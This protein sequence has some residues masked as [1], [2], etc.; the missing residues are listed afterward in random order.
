MKNSFSQKHPYISIILVGLICTFMTASGTAV[1]QIIGL[2]ENAQLEVTTVFLIISVAIGILIMSKSRFTLSDYG[3]CKSKKHVNKKVWW[4][5]PLFVVEIIPIAVAG[6]STEVTL[7]QYAI[8]LFFTTAVGFNE[9]IYFRGLAF[10]FL[11]EKGR[12][13]AI[14][15]TSVI[16]GILH[17][18]NALNGKNALY[19]VLQMLFAFMAG[20]VLV[21]IVSISKS[22]WIVIIWHAAHDYIAGVTNDVFD[23][24]KLIILAVQVVVLLIYAI[25]LWIRSNED[26][27]VTLG[28]TD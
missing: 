24:T 6:F 25:Y 26:N 16:F 2:N 13:R 3:F 14:V 10:K 17:L 1:P 8:L 27:M 23:T 15:C 28:V 11:E 7:V 18:A 5:I 22:L 20:F 12:R 9:E 4:Y 19:L 21:E